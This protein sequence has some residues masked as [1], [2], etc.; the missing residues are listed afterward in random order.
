MSVRDPKVSVNFPLVFEVILSAEI[1]VFP[2][3]SFQIILAFGL[4]PLTSH[5]ITLSKGDWA[6]IDKFSE[7]SGLT[8]GDT[9]IYYVISRFWSRSIT[10][11]KNAYFNPIDPVQV[12]PQVLDPI[13]LINP[14]AV[15]IRNLKWRHLNN[16]KSAN[17]EPF[18]KN[19]SSF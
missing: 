7:N 13:V 6:R 3:S 1:T 18:S 17:F 9:I 8:L 16:S 12:D 19:F 15:G 10:T 11:F 2:R 5:F 14:F 4:A